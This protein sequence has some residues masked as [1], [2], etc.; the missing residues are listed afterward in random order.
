MK[1]TV[2]V[3]VSA[4]SRPGQ[5]AVLLTVVAAAL[6]TAEAAAV[7]IAAEPPIAVV[8]PLVAAP[9]AVHSIAADPPIVVVV[10]QLV[11]AAVHSIV[12]ELPTVVVAPL[13]AAA[14]AFP[15]VAPSN[16]D[17]VAA[18]ERRYGQA[19]TH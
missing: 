11:A 3:R 12:A 10:D 7:H 14:A 4:D 5:P 1:R 8:V 9:A 2:T 16:V 6:P 13:V 18:A 15:I 17:K 19:S